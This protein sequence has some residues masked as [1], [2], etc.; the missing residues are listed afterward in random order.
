[1]IETLESIRENNKRSFILMLSLNSFSMSNLQDT[2]MRILHTA[3]LGKRRFD[4]N[5]SF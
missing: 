4:E 2:V 1:M 5:D 3:T